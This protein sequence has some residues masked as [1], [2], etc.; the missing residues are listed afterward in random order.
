MSELICSSNNM[1][2]LYKG[3]LMKSIGRMLNI[4]LFSFLLKELKIDN[5]ASSSDSFAV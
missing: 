3:Y 2:K 1:H 4:F 5:M